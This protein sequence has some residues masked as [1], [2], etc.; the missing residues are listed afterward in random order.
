MTHAV[1]N[2]GITSCAGC[3]LRIVY[4]PRAGKRWT[5]VHM[6]ITSRVLYTLL[7]RWA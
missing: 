2:A 7:G 3:R 6:R 1:S 5:I 4:A